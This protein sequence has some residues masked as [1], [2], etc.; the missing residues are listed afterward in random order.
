MTS[1]A[2]WGYSTIILERWGVKRGEPAH[3][4]GILRRLAQASITIEMV[5][6]SGFRK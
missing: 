3:L 2:Q 4:Y 5:L 6:D 1:V